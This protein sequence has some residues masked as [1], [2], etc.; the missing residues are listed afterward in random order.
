MPLYRTRPEFV[1]AIL[2][3]PETAEQV[4]RWTGGELSWDAEG[5]P[6]VMIITA[7][8]RIMALDHMYVVKDMKNQWNVMMIND[9]VGKYELL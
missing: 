1:E 9:F 3:M 7:T 8:G 2:L 5:K 6:Q 4:A